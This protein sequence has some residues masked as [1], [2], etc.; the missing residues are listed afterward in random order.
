MVI[1]VSGFIIFSPEILPPCP[2]FIQHKGR[3]H[4]PL[5]D[6][7]LRP[8]MGVAR[9]GDWIQQGETKARLAMEGRARSRP[10]LDQEV[11]RAPRKK[12]SN[13][14]TLMLKMRWQVRNQ[15]KGWENAGAEESR[16]GRAHN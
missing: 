16:N 15:V 3:A 1:C 12:P 9:R 5:T 11:P 2:L 13:T 7:I 10:G 8:W 4:P 14:V 6:M